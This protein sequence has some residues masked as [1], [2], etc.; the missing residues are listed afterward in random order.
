MSARPARTGWIFIGW[1]SGNFTFAP[2]AAL[3]AAMSDKTYTAVYE[4]D[5]PDGFYLIRPYWVPE[6]VEAAERFT[7]NPNVEGEY[8]LNVTLTEGE[9][10]TVAR[11]EGRKITALYPEDFLPGYTVDAEHAGSVTVYFRETVHEDWAEFGGYICIAQ[12]VNPPANP[13]TDVPADVWYADAVAWALKN[14]VTVGTSDTTFSPDQRCTR[15]QIVTFL[16]R[17]AGSPVPTQTEMPFTDVPGD[18]WYTTPVLWAVENNI[19]A[20]TSDTTF[21][22][23]QSCT[24]AQIVTFLWHA[25]RI[26]E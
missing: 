16:W 4:K 25:S 3:S 17:A 23:H 10:I 18:T 9:L 1:D 11:V 7:P 24:R 19:T 15:A 20:G 6:H 5:L 14:G 2:D 26:P 13:F 8:M 22:P 21:S 12:S